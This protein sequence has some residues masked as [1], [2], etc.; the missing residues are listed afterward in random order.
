MMEPMLQHV[1]EFDVWMAV[2]GH[3]KLGDE[4]S[5]GVFD[6][7]LR[8]FVHNVHRGIPNPPLG[9][10]YR[11]HPHSPICKNSREPPYT[12]KLVSILWAYSQHF[13]LRMHLRALEGVANRLLPRSNCESRRLSFQLSKLEFR[14][15][16]QQGIEVKI[17][18]YL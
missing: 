17:S 5:G 6:R 7:R 4:T 13:Q 2:L 16:G 18:L 14:C 10:Q 3:G 15:E 12:Q 8:A 9:W 11:L 1:S